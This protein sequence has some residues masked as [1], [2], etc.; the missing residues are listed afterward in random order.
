MQALNA[1]LHIKFDCE[2]GVYYVVSSNVMGLHAEAKELDEL[3]TELET[4]IPELRKANE[5]FT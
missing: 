4:L 2:V 5:R 3:M 1:E